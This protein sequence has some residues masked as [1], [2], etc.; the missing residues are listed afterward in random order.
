MWLEDCIFLG[1]VARKKNFCRALFR[2]LSQ[3]PNIHNGGEV[4]SDESTRARVLR[5]VEC[6]RNDYLKRTICKKEIVL[7]DAAA[8]VE[9]ISSRIRSKKGLQKELLQFACVIPKAFCA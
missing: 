9:K 4:S 6:V 7:V 3:Y 1:N 8:F 5:P 2:E